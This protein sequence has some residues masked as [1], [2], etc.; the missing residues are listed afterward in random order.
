[1]T[2]LLLNNENRKILFDKTKIY[3]E[4]KNLKEL[5]ERI[6]VKYK[7]LRK[8]SDGSLTTPIKIV[9]KEI[10]KCIEIKE[11]K[12]D[13]WG[14]KKGGIA[15]LRITRRKYSEKVQKEWRQKGGKKCRIKIADRLRE[16]RKYDPEKFYFLL[17]G[18]KLKKNAEKLFNKKIFRKKEIKLDNNNVLFSRNDEKRGI[19]IPKIMTRELAEEIGIHVGDGTL[20]NKE[21]YFSVRGGMDEEDYYTEFILPL[22]K[23][24]YNLDLKVL[25]RSRACGFE[26]NSKALYLF[27]NKTLGIV[28]GCK[29]NRV[30]IPKQIVCGDNKEIMQAFV[31]GVFD[32]DGCFYG[33]KKGKYPVISLS[34]KSKKA[35]VQIYKILKKLGFCPYLHIEEYSIY[36]NGPMR[37]IKWMRE[38]GTNNPKHKRRIEKIKAKLPW[39]N[40]DRLFA[41]AKDSS[42]D[43]GLRN[44]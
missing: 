44:Q 10:L 20:P 38:I 30:E 9:P 29:T 4:V 42:K 16:I 17:Y 15:G 39:S 6:G 28:T 31:R 27:K 37:F 34:I 14:A 22:Y 33:A 26:I 40:L 32:T 11:I 7:T 21:Y 13:N 2:R 12:E 8:Y 1:M 3:Y 43:V 41:E 24:V 35:I 36:L 5:A 23:R 18:K 19:V 25:K